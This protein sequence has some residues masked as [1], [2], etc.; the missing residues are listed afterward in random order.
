MRL[1]VWRTAALAAAITMGAGSE[2]FARGAARTMADLEARVTPGTE[3]DVVDRQGRVVRGEFAHAGDEGVLVTFYRSSGS[4]RVPARDVLS[5]SRP[6]D[7]VLNG[8]IIGAAFGALPVIGLEGNL[9]SREAVSI[10]ATYA[11]IGALIDLMIKGRTVVYRAPADRVSWSVAPRPV[12]R[13]AG[14]QVALKF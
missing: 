2:V 1:L 10:M 4:R 8:A 13:G 12:A 11:G 6:G 9:A 5:V 14:L 3:I 7:S